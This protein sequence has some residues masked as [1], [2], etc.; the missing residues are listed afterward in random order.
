VVWV[1]CFSMKM[2][3]VVVGFV[4]QWRSVRVAMK[5][6]VARCTCQD[7]TA[8]SMAIRST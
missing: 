3:V 2:V 1:S 8:L 7:F 5:L 6:V 4:W